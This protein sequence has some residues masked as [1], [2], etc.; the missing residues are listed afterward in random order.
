[1]DDV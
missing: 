1:M